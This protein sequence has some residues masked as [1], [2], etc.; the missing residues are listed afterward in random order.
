MEMTVKQDLVIDAKKRPLGKKNASKKAFRDE[1][2]A[3]VYYS[4]SENIP[5]A[6]DRS[7]FEKHIPKLQSNTIFELDI[8]GD[9][10]RAIIQDYDFFL[11][12]RRV[13][14]IDFLGIEKGRAFKVGIPIELKSRAVGVTKGGTL[15][16]FINKVRV[17]CKPEDIPNVLEIDIK[18]LDVGDIVYIRDL[19]A[20]HKNLSFLENPKKPVVAVISSRILATAEAAEKAE[21]KEEAAPAAETKEKEKIPE[22]KE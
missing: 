5:I 17:L 8:D 19:A 9:K 7:I 6:I 10:K 14:H 22:K 20:Q 15:R 3:C 12:N 13:S 2:I 18:N 11:S 4:Q 1:K 16:R 21:E